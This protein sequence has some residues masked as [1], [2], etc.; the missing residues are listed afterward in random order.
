[1]FFHKKQKNQEHDFDVDKTAIIVEYLSGAI[2]MYDHVDMHVHTMDPV[3]LL[4]VMHEY[5]AK[6]LRFMTKLNAEKP[7]RS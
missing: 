4:K 2:E 6:K 7:K 5:E 1:M 3:D